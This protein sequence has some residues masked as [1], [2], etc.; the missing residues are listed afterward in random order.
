MFGLRPALALLWFPLVAAPAPAPPVVTI[1]FHDFS[2]DAPATLPAGA[3][4]FKGVN[5]GKNPH[6][7]MLI[8]LAA[9]KSATDL[10]AALAK[11]GPPP[12][13]ATMLGG[14]Q[15]G[16]EVTLN[17]AAGNYVWICMVPGPDGAPHIAKGMMKPFTVTPSKAPAPLPTADLTASMADYT[18]TFSKPLTTG[19]HVVKFTTAPGQPH[20]LV[21]W[22]LAPG[23]TVKDLA[24]WAEK[25]N[26]PP[27]AQVVGGVAP[28]QAGIDNYATLNLTAGSY[29]LICFLPDAKDG[30][31]HMKHGMVQELTLK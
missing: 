19:R 22:K 18:W 12:T 17:L 9:G 25:L 20:E 21:I 10:V 24:A 11:P 1:G 27:P 4:T 30:K 28:A 13:W 8:K 2:F 26:G 23:K 7:G 29:A 5:L 16:S 31:E 14:P 6:H 15:E 3:V